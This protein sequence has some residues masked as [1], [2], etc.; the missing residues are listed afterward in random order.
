[1]HNAH[2]GF[3]IT[4]SSY[5]FFWSTFEILTM[6]KSFLL[7]TPNSTHEARITLVWQAWLSAILGNHT[8]LSPEFQTDTTLLRIFQW[9]FR[10]GSSS[11]D[12]LHVIPSVPWCREAA[13]DLLLSA[14]PKIQYCSMGLTQAAGFVDTHQMVDECFQSHASSFHFIDVR[15][16]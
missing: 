2:L 16:R 13:P 3:L 6:C 9:P 10:T 12:V 8:N 5:T 1:M 4:G 14:H 7:I 11:V 15:K